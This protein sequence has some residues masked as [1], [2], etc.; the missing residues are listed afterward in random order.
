[1]KHQKIFAAIGTA[2]AL[3]VG[4]PSARAEEEV[5][6]AAK[7][8]FAEYQDSVVWISA[9]AKI[10]IKTSGGSDR[11]IPDQEKKVE[12]PGTVIDAS[13][14]IVTSLNTIDPSSTMDGQ[15]F[16]S[17]NGPVKI[18]ASAK[19]TEVK[20]IM[21]DGAEIPADIVM[22]DTDLD[23]AFI[24]IRAD[25]PEAKGV[26]FKAIDLKNCA[27]GGML[28]EVVAL[29]RMGEVFGRQPSVITSLVTAETKKPRHFLRVP[30]ETIGGPVFN[31]S[32]KLIGITVL[33]HAKSETQGDRIGL[34]P[35]VMPAA[36]IV[37]LAE[38][39]LK[40]KPPQSDEKKVAEKSEK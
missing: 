25:S 38:Q 23:L 39:A 15:E 19:I 24:K 22:K 29:G 12:T 9:V 1:M 17:P 6:K 14:L 7:K 8:I 28:D 31:V 18:S 35:A 11:S 30:T 2:V 13:G 10:S 20:V 26:K 21:P 40:A 32:G 37:P 3:A 5:T 36:D 4:Q 27:E 33:R 34:L 16:P